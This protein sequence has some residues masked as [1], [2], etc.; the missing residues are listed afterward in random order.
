MSIQHLWHTGMSVNCFCVPGML[1]GPAKKESA[2]F[3]SM[4]PAQPYRL[5]TL[6]L[7]EPYTVNAASSDHE[8]KPHCSVPRAYLLYFLAQ[9]KDGRF[10]LIP[11]MTG[12]NLF[13]NAPYFHITIYSA[14]FVLFLC[15]SHIKYFLS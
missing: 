8:G 1:Y 14:D 9:K 4:K 7:C 13:L 15:I 2:G 10:C 11:D 3:R 12:M 6:T 5:A